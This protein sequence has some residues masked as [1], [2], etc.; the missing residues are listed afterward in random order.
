[1]TGLHMKKNTVMSVALAV[2][3][4]LALVARAEMK[5]VL[6]DGNI[7]QVR[8]LI[9]DE[10]AL[11]KHGEK[12]TAVAFDR[13]PRANLLHTWRSLGVSVLKTMRNDPEL[14]PEH[15]RREAGFQAFRDGADG[16][17]L[18]DGEP[19]GEWARA[20]QEAKE[21]WR[22]LEYVT[23]LRE[24]ALASADGLIRTE[25]R[26]AKFYLQGY[27]PSE[28]EN[29]D[30]LRLECTAWAKRLEQ[31]L[32]LPSAKLPVAPPEKPLPDAADFEPYAS[33]KDALVK[34]VLK[35][36]GG[37]VELADGLSFA[38]NN[39]GFK[40]IVETHKGKQLANRWASPGGELDFRLYLPGK[41]PG[42]W[43]PYRYHCDLNP[44]VKGEV[45]APA[46]GRGELLYGTDER[47]LPY[48]Q[49]YAAPNIRV[50]EWPR[51]RSHGPD[52]PDLRPTLWIEPLKGPGYRAELRVDWMSLYGRWPLAAAGKRG[53]IWYVG[54]DRSP[55]TG[56]PVAA[57]IQWPKGGG[58][59]FDKVCSRFS[60]GA[61]TGIYMEELDRTYERWMSALRS[62]Y[63]EFPKTKEPCFNIGDLESDEMFRTRLMQ[64]LVDANENAWKLIQKDKEHPNPALRQQ[65]EAVQ[66]S[67]HKMLGR[68][69]YLSHAVG[70][71]RRDY[72]AGRFAGKVPPEVAK[73]AAKK[74]SKPVGL[75]SELEDD[76]IELD[77]TTY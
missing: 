15:Y 77:E 75:D 11:A 67:I 20:L 43:M 6:P 69:L 5:C 65:P 30:T 74:E 73:K 4:L 2:V 28:W 54:L 3:G 22:V 70:L 52:C 44:R 64:P 39:D 55:E 56:A 26:R 50:M 27:L 23:G 16:L 61:L 49:A 17:Y 12:A 34:G 31:L 68:M 76:P 66:A 37:T 45:R 48:A 13:L 18:A 42:E 58:V 59:V 40:L 33:C 32:G 62:R 36:G 10:I 46:R 7:P 53:D 8:E 60:P 9:D 24:K 38:W 35:A 63:Y 72:L 57:R 1:M 21:D 25:G 51:L 41:K 19:S 47:F 14:S 71:L 29:L